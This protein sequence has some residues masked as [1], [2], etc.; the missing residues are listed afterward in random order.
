M[1]AISKAL[2]YIARR[3]RSEDEVRNFLA[4]K[5]IPD[6]EAESCIEYLIQ[7]DYIN[8]RR[9]AGEIFA[10]LSRYKPAGKIRLRSELIKRGFDRGLV[11]ETLADL[12][13]ECEY[14]LA[15]QVAQKKKFASGSKL[16]R[17]LL[18]R[19]FSYQVTQRVCRH[20]F[21]GKD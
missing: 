5:G 16:C 12:D 18:Y 13:T 10:Y 6:F 2:N 19:G 8:D 15:C 17:H 11:E 4:R 14:Q 3:A 1:S 21:V 20:F 9:T 7:A